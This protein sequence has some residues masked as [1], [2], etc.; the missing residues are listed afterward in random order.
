MAWE[1]GRAHRQA[2][3][4]IDV[5]IGRVCARCGKPTAESFA[6]VCTTCGQAKHERSEGLHGQQLEELG[7]NDQSC[8]CGG[9]VLVEF[10]TCTHCG[11][12]AEPL[13]RAGVHDVDLTVQRVPPADGSRQNQLVVLEWGAIEPIHASFEPLLAAVKL[14]VLFAPTP[15]AKQAEILAAKAGGTAMK[16]SA[17][18]RAGYPVSGSGGR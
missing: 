17:V 12:D 4:E 14:N 9:K 18:A 5:E 6:W 3:A 10:V 11:S 16:K 15:L 8:P 2:I 7:C 13:L 1:F